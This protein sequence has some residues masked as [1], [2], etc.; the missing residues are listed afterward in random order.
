MYYS[1]VSEAKRVNML[2]T[3]VNTVKFKK[4]PI[5]I[6]SMPEAAKWRLLIGV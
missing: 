3:F 5:Y 2:N 4:V 1:W 6:N